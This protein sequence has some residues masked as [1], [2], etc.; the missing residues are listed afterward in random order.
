MLSEPLLTQKSHDSRALLLACF[1]VFFIEMA[2]LAMLAPFFGTSPAGLALGS[3]RVG[4]I[5][6]AFP[7]GTVLTT[8][9]PPLALARWGGRVTVGL[10]MALSAVTNLLF[11]MCACLLGAPDLLFVGLIAV[12][13]VGGMAAGLGSAGSFTMLS[14]SEFCERMGIVMASAELT[15]AGITCLHTPSLRKHPLCTHTHTL[16]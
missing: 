15:S 9:L 11:G 1:L 6:A 16:T 8:P 12:R 3:E 4:V 2:C 14:T 13:L 5:F 7:L 10:G